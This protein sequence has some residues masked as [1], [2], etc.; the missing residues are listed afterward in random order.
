MQEC[1][2]YK[3]IDEEKVQ[4]QNCHH[5]CIISEG[6]VGICGVRKNQKGKLSLLVFGKI[7]AVNID[8]IEKKPLFHF[9]PDSKAFSLGTLGCN[10]RCAN[11]QNFNI[12]QIYGLKGSV[13]KYNEID[14]GY[15]LS[16]EEVVRQA[17]VNDC[18]SIAYTYNEPTIFLEY[19]LDTM[20]LARKAG[21]KNVW[22]SNGFMSDQALDLIIP[23]LDAINIDIKSF[24][25]EFY[26]NNCGAHLKPILE[27]CKKL[28]R[29]G[30]WLEITTLV[31]PTLSDDE[32]MLRQVARFIKKELGDF[33]PWHVSAFSGAI[34]WKLQNLPDTSIVKIKRAYDIGKEEGLKYVYVGNVL[35][36]NLENTYC[37]HCGKMVIERKGYNIARMDKGGK[38]QKCHEKMDGMMGN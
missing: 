22:V 18:K 9:L 37:K 25:D 26:R 29:R 36:K 8:P 13:D 7:I 16:P 34:S 24:N 35:E 14:W 21:L 20:K 12:S 28:V 11:C 27:N 17:Q 6:Q 4:C 5:F 33:V 31:I 1:L 19:A 10:F 38:C 32:E 2:N 23:Y 30:I 3:K 15:Q